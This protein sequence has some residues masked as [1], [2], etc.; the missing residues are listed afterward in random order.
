MVDVLTIAVGYSPDYLLK[1][2][3]TGRENYYTGAVVEGEP[4]GRW[5]GAGAESLGLSGLVEAHDMTGLYER[6]LDPRAEG[7]NDKS[8]W[9]ELPTLGHTGRRY[10]SE[11]ELYAAALERELN[12]SPERRVELRTEAGKAARRNVAFLDVTFSVQKSVTLLHTAFEAEQV[13]ARAAGAESTAQAW[14]KFRAAVEDAIWAGNNAALTYLSEKAGYSR[15]GHHGGAAGRFVDA[16]DWTVA[17]FFQHDSRD[18]DPQLH[19]HNAVLNRVQGPDGIWRTV[20]SRAMHKWRAAA[21]AVAERTTEERLSHALGMA[22]ATRPDGKSREVVGVSAEAIALISSRRRAVTAKA[23]ELIEAFETQFDRSPN[24]LERDRLSRQA[25]FATRRAKSHDGQTREQLLTRVDAQLRSEVAGGLAGVAQAALDAREAQSAP[26]EWSP[27]AVIETALADVQER[28]AGWTRSDL[29]R[30]INATLPDYLGTPDGSDVARLLD[31]LADEALAYA[32]PLDTARPGED[33]L[34]AELRLDNGQSAYQAPGGQ[35]Y[36]TPEHVCTERILLAATGDNTGAAV[37]PLQVQRFLDGLRESGIELGVD[38]AAAVRGILTSGARVETLVG[39]AGT[40]KSFVVGALA[41]AW[42]DPAHAQDGVERRVFGL[43]TSQIATEVLVA[44]GLTAR[45]V[46][47]WLA[48]QNRLD[49]SPADQRLDDQPWRLHVGDLVVVDESAMTDTPALAAIHSRVDKVGAKLLLVGDHRQLAAVGAGGGMDLIAGTGARYELTDARR[50]TDEWERTASLRLRAGDE[51][52][53]R[54]YFQHGRLLDSGAVEQAETSASRAWLADTLAGR[55]SLLLVDTNDQAARLSAALRADLVRLGRVAEDGV[56][57]GLQGT[58]AGVGDLVQARANGWDLAGVEGNRRGPIN[59]ETYRVTATRPDG[60]LEVATDADER[61]VLPAGYVAENLALAYA[62]TVHAAQ[63]A[64]VDTS[65]TVVT[66]RTGHEAFYVGMSRGRHRN[67]AHITTVTGP[68]DPAHGRDD[69]TIHRDPVAAVA[70]IL[71]PDSS[72][73][74]QS[75]LATATRSADETTSVRTPAELFTDAAQ[76][77]ATHRTAVWL[78]ELTADGTLT[79][80][81][82]RR[83]AAEDG[84]ASLTRVLR[85]AEVAGHDPRAVLT[86]AIADRP[87]D[88]ARNTTNVIYSRIT[89]RHRF[90]PVGTSWEAWMPRVDNPDWQRYLAQLAL[91]VDDRTIELGRAAAAEPPTWALGAFG[92]P[93]IASDARDAWVA[94]VG[95]VAAY[96]ELRDHAGDTDVLGAAP[97]PGQVEQFA[98]YR[99]AWRVLGRPEVDREELE[100]SDGQ[101]RM[102]VRAA[103][104]EAPW[105]PRYVGNELAGTRQAVEHH[106]QTAALRLEESAVAP[107]AAV[108]AELRVEAEQARALADALDQQLEQ[109]E[110]LDDARSQWLAHTAATRAAGERAQAELALRHADDADPEQRVTAEEWLRAHRDAFRADEEHQEITA[111]YEFAPPQRHDQAAAPSDIR[112]EAGRERPQAP[113]DT[114]RVPTAAETA[115]ALDRAHRA[116]AEISARDAYEQDQEAADRAAELNSWGSEDRS[117]EHALDEALDYA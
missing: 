82:R 40:G 39:P 21:G 30:A 36:A 53:L 24:G 105:A 116:M 86:S 62:S 99:A 88:G 4:P 31:Q 77:A 34:P 91:A 32:T 101:L 57:L 25:T 85:S 55:R 79:L 50:F 103:E 84:A 110:Q 75:A 45:N 2:V 52:V 48:I 74:A 5:W 115:A 33:A 61:I 15:V 111:D 87:L 41:K 13:K 51:A 114:V 37:H 76:L 27:Q 81:D 1:E 102:R 98:A 29:T 59:R 64:T 69:Q 58:Y 71:A 94:D 68:D 35:L 43:A 95:A 44:E 113:E 11:D 26:Q 46:A 66:P 117:E 90:D 60:S 3:A 56:V 38:Q 18:H 83:I 92:T 72:T 67:T 12:A 49:A 73:A 28:K 47:A 65:H 106:R 107:N 42:A 109:L 9:D 97:Q 63:G 93:P 17:S 10:Q 16:H 80:H 6:F 70:A 89:D 22:F 54:D 112:D 104:R 19:I 108:Q 14:G 96:R 8:R 7:F 23:A 100:L 20:D 78:D